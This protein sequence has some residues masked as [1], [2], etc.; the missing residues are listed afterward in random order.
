MAALALTL[1]TAA[2]A[3]AAYSGR[4][5]ADEGSVDLGAAVCSD[6]VTLHG[7]LNLG[8][9]RG[10]CFLCDADSQEE[11]NRLCQATCLADPEVSPPLPRSFCRP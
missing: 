9:N 7:E 8:V 6:T 1:L 5:L 4:E 10:G 3:T 2:T 11:L